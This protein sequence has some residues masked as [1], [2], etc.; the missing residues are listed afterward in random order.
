MMNDYKN[1]PQIRQLALIDDYDPAVL[2]KMEKNFTE[3]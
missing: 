3:T 1:K 2:A